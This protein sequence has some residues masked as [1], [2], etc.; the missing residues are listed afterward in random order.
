MVNDNIF[1]GQIEQK[2]L[3]SRM[4]SSASPK[5]KLN[6]NKQIA[7]QHSP[8]RPPW[9]DFLVPV[10]IDHGECVYPTRIGNEGSIDRSAAKIWSK[11]NFGGVISC[12]FNFLQRH[13]RLCFSSNF[14]FTQTKCRPPALTSLIL[15]FKASISAGFEASGTVPPAPTAAAASVA[16]FD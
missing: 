12:D 6:S 8:G 9:K 2:Q 1:F 7:D 5:K 3:I 4:M 14:S 11:R 16:I 13:M 10:S 15:A